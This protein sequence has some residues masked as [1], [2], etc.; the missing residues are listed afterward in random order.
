MPLVRCAANPVLS[1]KDVPFDASLIF[2]AGVCRYRGKYVMV[3]RN[4]AGFSPAGWEKG[5]THTNLGIAFSD[6]GVKWRV[7]PEPWRAAAEFVASSPEIGR[8]Y[9]PRLTVIDG[10]CYLCFAVDTKH[11][12]RGG[13]A[14]TDD[15]ERLEILSL[16]TPDNRNMVLFPEKIGGRFFRLERPFPEYSREYQERF[17]VWCSCSPDCRFWGESR[18]VLGT[19]DVP[20][21][22]AKIGPA[23]PPVKTAKGWLAT[24]HAV[25]KD[26]SRTLFGWET[27]NDPEKTWH[28]EY[29]AGL[30]LLDPDDPA[31]VIGISKKPVLK[32]ETRYELEG[33]RGSV[34][35]PGGM[36]L[37]PDGEV[38]IYYGG[39]DTV[40]CLATASVDDLL[41]LIEP[42]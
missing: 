36:I 2:N 24:F 29:F 40:E 22:N 18:L 1:A 38:K 15:F 20:F 14:V 16:S 25:W 6:D 42:L 5:A 23:A 28:K 3:F 19:E 9:D 12:V 39:A 21:C 17:D 26:K 34:I 10:R 8:I 30:M 37:E 13:I 4:D 27:A 7:E 31:K 35:F 32:A 11:G 33:F 41:A